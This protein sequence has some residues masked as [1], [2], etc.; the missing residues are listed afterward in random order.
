[1][2]ALVV[3]G[4][5]AVDIDDKSFRL[6]GV[7]Y[8]VENSV[9]TIHLDDGQPIA[10]TASGVAAELFV[11]TDGKFR[12]IEM[13]V[14]DTRTSSLLI[15]LVKRKKLSGRDLRVN[16]RVSMEHP[17]LW[18]RLDSDGHIGDQRRGATRD[19]SLSGIS[20]ETLNSPPEVGEMIAISGMDPEHSGA[21]IALVVGVDD[22]PSKRRRHVIRCA[23]VQVDEPSRKH[24]V[25]L[26]SSQIIGPEAVK[27]SMKDI[28]QSK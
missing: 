2:N 17:L 28:G 7:I 8:S 27:K 9:V 15:R 16:E 18:A 13:E 19:I 1:M 20:Y 11:E 12:Q 24:L 10:D 21:V 14:L 22:A 26:I 5:V 4:R 25:D 23:L 3:G 6:L